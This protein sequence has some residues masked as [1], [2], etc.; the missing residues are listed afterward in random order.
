MGLSLPRHQRPAANGGI[1]ATVS[2]SDPCSM[3][4][5]AEVA[6]SHGVPFTVHSRMYRLTVA[7]RKTVPLRFSR[8]ALGRLASALAHH[9]PILATV[10]A[11]SFDA[12]GYVQDE[13]GGTRLAI[14]A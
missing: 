1:L 13:T 4:A 6:I 14:H 12:H 9:R 8:A 10:F 3:G 2:C 5:F 7:G 11:V